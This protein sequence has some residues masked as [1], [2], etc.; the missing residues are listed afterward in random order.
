MSFVSKLLTPGPLGKLLINAFTPKPAAQQL[1]EI[2]QQTAQEAEP[3]PIVFGRLRPIGGNLIHCQAPVVLWL[4]GS[5]GGKGGG[6]APKQANIFRTYAIGVCEGPI[7]AFLRIWRNGKLVY[8]ARGND[9]GERNNP[10]FLRNYRLYLGG[11]GQLPDPS[12]EQIWGVGQVPAY[13]GTAYLVAVSENLTD[14]GGAVPQWQFEVARAEGSFLTSQPYGLE[15]VETVAVQGAAL[16][17]GS[18]QR[19]LITAPDQGPEAVAVAG[20]ELTGGSL[21]A[22]VLTL[23]P[24]PEEVTVVGALLTGGYLNNAL[25]A[26]PDQGPETVAVTGAAL[27]GGYLNRALVDYA[28]PSPERLQLTGAELTGGSLG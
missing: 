27:T 17:G 3:R 18:L 14:L 22:P 10:V 26:A 2:A 20:A 23:V 9:W 13:R 1:G 15:D 7:T 12:L 25:V 19:V 6:K 21:T 11:W 4:R 24:D 28:E 5:G 8:D 16:T